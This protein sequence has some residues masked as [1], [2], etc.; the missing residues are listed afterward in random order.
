MDRDAIRLK[1]VLLQEPLDQGLPHLVLLGRH[2]LVER[3]ELNP[4]RVLVGADRV[5][6]LILILHKL[7]DAARAVHHVVAAYLGLW[8]MEPLD[9][10]AGIAGLRS[11]DND[12]LNL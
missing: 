1:L 7:E 2:A 3:T 6:G 8:I 5:P 4:K 12:P 10:R 11:V 9:G